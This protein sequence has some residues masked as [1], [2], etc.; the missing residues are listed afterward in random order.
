MT[1]R[2]QLRHDLYDRLMESQYASSERRLNDQRLHLERLLRHA[3]A[4]VPFYATRLDPVFTAGGDVDWD[5]WSEIPILTR[6]DLLTKREEMLSSRLPKYQGGVASES[7]TGSTGPPVTVNRSDYSADILAATIHR[8]RSWHH[9]DWSRDLFAWIDDNEPLTEQ[10]GPEW[11]PTWL[12]LATGKSYRLN[13]QADATTVLDFLRRLRPGYISMRPKNAQFLALEA[14]RR[15]LDLRFDALLGYSTA[16]LPDERA[17]CMRA[18]GARTIGQYGSK[19]GHNIA[20]QCPT[21]HHYHV[22]DESVQVEVL[23]EDGLPVGEGKMGRVVITQIHNMAQPVIRYDQ[24]DLAVRGKACSCGRSLTVLERIVGRTTHLF[25]FPDGSNVAPVIPDGFRSLLSAQYWQIAQ[26]EPLLIEVRYV[27]FEG[28]TVRPADRQM[29]EEI[30]RNRTHPDATVRLRPVQ[31]LHRID[32]GK[33]VELVSELAP[34][35]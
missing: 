6:R 28:T 29:V 16:I 9:L 5:R 34:T 3:R 25:R 33:F 26:V 1:S 17:D 18:F 30:V 7:T 13:R 19:E 12:P 23:D 21:G 8:G 15:G 14:L 22:N 10:A 4:L 27:P 20:Y 2:T 32:G 24:G 35:S 31:S 11:G